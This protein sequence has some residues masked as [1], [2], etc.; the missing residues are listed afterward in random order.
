MFNSNSRSTLTD[1]ATDKQN[2]VKRSAM[3]LPFINPSDSQISHI[4]RV[5]RGIREGVGEDVSSPVS[6]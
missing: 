4:L 1:G 2:V 3:H 6:H 5:T